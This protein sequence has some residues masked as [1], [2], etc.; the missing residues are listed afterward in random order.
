MNVADLIKRLH[1]FANKAVYV[2]VPAEKNPD[3]KGADGFK[4]AE[5]AAVHEFGSEDGRIPQR[6]FLRTSVEKNAGKYF[7]HLAKNAVNGKPPE[8]ILNEIS[9][10]AVGDVQENITNGDFVPLKPK[11]IKRKGS[12]KPLI[13]TGRLRQS[14]TGVVREN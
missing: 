11:T 1:A 7:H 8:Q 9:A 14:I 6:S 10:M 13:D 2:G 4:M 5:L 3:V 12:S